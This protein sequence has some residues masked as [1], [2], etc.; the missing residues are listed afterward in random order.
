MD[1]TELKPNIIVNGPSFPEP[2]QVIVVVPMGAAVKL[3]GNPQR[4]AGAW[5]E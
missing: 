2:V 5:T 1:K 4:V 3:I